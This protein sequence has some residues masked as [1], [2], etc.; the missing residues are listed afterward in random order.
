M[1]HS[2]GLL[3]RENTEQVSGQYPGIVHPLTVSK[4][5]AFAYKVYKEQD[6]LAP[7]FKTTFCKAVMIDFLG[8]WFV[9]S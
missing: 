2:V 5:V 9:I 6:P 1:L 7:S 8:V 3:P 4:Q